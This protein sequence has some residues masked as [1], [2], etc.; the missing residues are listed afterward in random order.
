MDERIVR[1]LNYAEDHFSKDMDLKTVA[2][3][4]C[5]SPYHF[6]RLFKRETGVSFKQFVDTLKMEKA[7]QAVVMGEQTIAELALELGYNDYETFSRRFKKYHRVSPDDLK[8]ILQKLPS[9]ARKQESSQPL[10]VIT[11]PTHDMEAITKKLADAVIQG[12][13]DDINASEVKVFV[14]TRKGQTE[15]NDSLIT[16]KNKYEMSSETRLWE[17]V[18]HKLKGP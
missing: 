18:I 4:A 11:H 1:A 10:I 3:E 5:I 2:R 6:H 17:K 7:Y 9:E 8:S 16:I 14:V 12:N 13:Y 15:G